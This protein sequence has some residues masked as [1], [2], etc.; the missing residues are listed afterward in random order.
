MKNYF[1]HIITFL[2]LIIGCSNNNTK[3]NIVTNY[4]GNSE[5]SPVSLEE[6]I[7]KTNYQY[8]LN[9]PIRTWD[10][11]SSLMEV[12]GNTWVDK[13]HLLLIDD[14][15]PNLYLI[16][17]DDKKAILEKIIP[18]QNDEKDKFD[19]EDV[20]IVDNVVYAL[21]SHGILFKISKWNTNPEVKEIPTFLSKGNNTEGICY[22]PVTKNLLIACKDAS[23]IDGEEK[24]T[25]AIYQFNRIT[26]KIV[27]E[28][29]L[30]IHKKDFKTLAGHKLVFYP[31][32]IAVH[33]IT[34]NIYLLSTRENKCMAIFNR[35]GALISFQFIDENL[36]PQPEGICFSPEGKLYI[37]SEGKKGDLG[38]LLEFEGK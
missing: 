27:E 1:L 38:K 14:R 28:P 24:S 13:N 9:N 32:A 12:S 3:R 11:P 19:I 36:M 21:W 2:L 16:K 17:I 20:T 4:G 15:H 33:P 10:L 29:F 18:F 5:A 31:S 25:K 8:D 7:D 35:A 23:G 22:D 26:E 30:I 37:S 6:N 34:H